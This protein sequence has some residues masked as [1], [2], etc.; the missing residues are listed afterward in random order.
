M[1]IQRR[2]KRQNE[3]PTAPLQ[4]QFQSRPFQDANFAP[5]DKQA[6]P[7][8]REFQGEASGFNLGSIPLF[9]NGNSTPTQPIQ[10]REED[11]QMQAESKSPLHGRFQT[12]AQRDNPK[13]STP[14]QPIQAKLTVGAVG[15]K[16]EQEADRV[17]DVVVDRIQSPPSSPEVQKQEEETLQQ[18]PQLSTPPT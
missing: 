15:D 18:K 5:P 17:A 3:S 6:A 14:Q 16:Y 11:V 7:P 2:K 13:N 12:L 8:E 9:S 1:K 4:A 10:R